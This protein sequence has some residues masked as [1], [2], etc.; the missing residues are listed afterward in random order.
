MGWISP[1][2][3]SSRSST[4]RWIV[5]LTA[6]VEANGRR[7]ASTASL[8]K[9]P[10]KKRCNVQRQQRSI[11]RGQP[12][13]QYEKSLRDRTKKDI[14]SPSWNLEAPLTGCPTVMKRLLLLFCS[15]QKGN[16]E[17]W[18]LWAMQCPNKN[19]KRRNAEWI[20][21]WAHAV[22]ARGSDGHQNVL[23]L[24]SYSHM[25]EN[26]WKQK[27]RCL[28]AKTQPKAKPKQNKKTPRKLGE[29]LR[30]QKRSPQAAQYFFTMS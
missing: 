4:R 27:A 12:R 26:R 25:L 22:H 28:P 14:W 21:F 9:Q 2:K 5:K 16:P 24:I 17:Q 10:L 13:H 18:R 6:V 1:S 3:K 23:S 15:W 7:Q 20:F 11:A 30:F 19:R 8:N 29:T